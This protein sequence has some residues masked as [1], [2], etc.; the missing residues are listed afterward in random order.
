MLGFLLLLLLILL[1]VVCYYRQLILSYFPSV[2]RRYQRLPAVFSSNSFHNDIENGLTSETFDLE[3]NLIDGD[4]RPGLEDSEE[5]KR[6]MKTDNVTF[7]QA[8]LIRQQR[9]FKTNNIDPQTGLPKDPKLVTF[10]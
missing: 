4:S 2:N 10:S 1:L 3:Q 9:K 8:R 6:I 5:I 7:D